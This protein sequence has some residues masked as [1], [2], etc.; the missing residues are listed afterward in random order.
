MISRKKRSRSDREISEH[1]SRKVL[2]KL[3]APGQMAGAGPTM[4]LR[5]ENGCCS[6]RQ[7]SSSTGVSAGSGSGIEGQ[8]GSKMGAPRGN[9]SSQQ[10][11]GFLGVPRGLSGAVVPRVGS[12]RGGAVLALVPPR[13]GL[14]R[15]ARG[16]TGCAAPAAAGG[17]AQQDNA[18]SHDRWTD[19]GRLLPLHRPRLQCYPGFGAGVPQAVGSVPGEC[20]PAWA[21]GVSSQVPGCTPYFLGLEV[22]A[23]KGRY[24]PWPA[25]L[26]L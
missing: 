9:C 13:S 20:T 6:R 18:H 15:G 3:K 26:M 11:L 4:L 25:S 8:S 2:R 22:T 10:P 7:S 24:R 12:S 19:I 5:E 17:A 14:R 16:L 1:R 23:H 21:C